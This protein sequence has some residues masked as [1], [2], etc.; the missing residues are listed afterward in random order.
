MRFRLFFLLWICHLSGCAYYG[1]IH[2]HSTRFTPA[3]LDTPHVYVP[4]HLP[5]TNEWWEGFHDPQ[6]NQL[7]TI[8]LADSPTMQ[9]AKNRV[10][11]AEYLVE[12]KMVPLIPTLDFSGYVQRQRFSATGLIP[13]PF[14]GRTFGVGDV[15]LNFNYEFDFWGKNWQALSSQISTR[16]ALQADLAEARL[17]LSA[18]VANAYFQL[19]NN[20]EQANFAKENWRDN[21]QL[22]NIILDRAKNGIESDIP[23]KTAITDMQ[24]SLLAYEQFNQ[25]ITLSKDQLAVL[26]GKN[27]F[28]TF[29]ITRHFNYQQHKITLPPCLTLN[30]LAHRPDIYAAKL[31]AEAAAKQICV[32]KARFFPNINLNA[33]LSLQSIELNHLFDAA[34]QNNAIT[35]AIDLP[36]FDA[37]LRRANLG[38]SYAEYDEAVNQYNQTILTALRDVADQQATFKSFSIQLNAENAAVNATANNYKLFRSRYNHGIIDYVQLLEI[39]Q[40]LLQQ[41]ALQ[42]NLQA[43]TLQAAIGLL[44]ALGGCD[45]RQGR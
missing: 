32:A 26:L 45:I 39:K 10:R 9:I 11:R 38:V 13:P 17:V 23:V 24:A 1:D 28:S 20:I 36:I 31:R 44:K 14:N 34:N 40:V 4:P 33:L 15:A 18:A 43:H 16:C 19:L 42:T 8:A 30:I 2:G 5:I 6:L 3:I 12:S 37:G 29:F 7:I 21:Q 35:G 25:A 27:P 22:A 41:Q